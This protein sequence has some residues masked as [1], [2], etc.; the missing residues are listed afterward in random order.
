MINPDLYTRRASMINP[1]RAPG[2]RNEATLSGIR[3]GVGTRVR[4]GMEVL[5]LDESGHKRILADVDAMTDDALRT[6]A[7]A[8]RPLEPG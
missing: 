7:V 2:G 6:L 8:Y 1:R 5:A 3:R 4:R